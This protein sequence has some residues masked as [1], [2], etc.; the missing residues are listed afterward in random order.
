MLR[1]HQTGGAGS[2]E[3]RIPR[4]QVRKIPSP[5]HGFFL[6]ASVVG[7]RFRESDF[8]LSANLVFA[9]PAWL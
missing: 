5:H 9:S 3:F 8:V 1:H 7:A 2:S 6:F 4:S